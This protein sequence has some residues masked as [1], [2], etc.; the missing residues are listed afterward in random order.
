MCVS[1]DL[2]YDHSWISKTEDIVCESQLL[3]NFCRKVVPP[4]TEHDDVIETKT[5]NCMPSQIDH[6]KP[7]MFT[8]PNLEAFNWLTV[9]E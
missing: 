5:R 7:R 2:H 3:G 8:D 9:Y 6:A 1:N 4:S